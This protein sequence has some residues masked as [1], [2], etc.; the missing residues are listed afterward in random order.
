MDPLWAS[1]VVGLVVGLLGFSLIRSAARKI[2]PAGLAPE[3][4]ARQFQKDAQLV[5]EQVQ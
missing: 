1:L 4:S 5:K 2:T 3:R